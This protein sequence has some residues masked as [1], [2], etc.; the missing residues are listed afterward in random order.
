MEPS[1]HVTNQTSNKETHEGKQ[2][3]ICID[4]A[5]T[6]EAPSIPGLPERFK[7][8]KLLGQ[9]GMG[10]VY[11]VADQELGCDLAVKIMSREWLAD[12][13][14]LQRFEVEAAAAGELCHPHIAQVYGYSAAGETPY[15]TMEYVEGASFDR[16][17]K[18]E[19]IIEQERLL[20]MV[21]QICDALEYAHLH[22]I[23]HRDLKPSNII[24]QD[25]GDIVKLVDFGI[26]KVGPKNDS[27]TQ[28]TQKG[29][30]FG[31]PTYMSPEQSHAGTVDHRT[32]LYS[33]GCIIYEAL[34]G[35][36]LFTGDNAVQILLHHINT[37]PNTSTRKLLKK[38][39][40]K[41]LIAILEKLLQKRPEQRYQSAAEVADDIRRVLNNQM[42]FAL[43][44]RPF[45]LDISKRGVLTG[46]AVAGTIA[47]IGSCSLTALMVAR[48]QTDRPANQGVYD[49]MIQRQNEARN[50]VDKITKSNGQDV[51]LAARALHLLV[52]EDVWFGRNIGP[53]PVGTPKDLLSADDQKAI[54]K[55]YSNASGDTR[56]ELLSVLTSMNNP[57]SDVVNFACALCKSKDSDTR[58]VV[59]P[60][61]S[62]WPDLI[63]KK[64]QPQLSTALSY[65]LLDNKESQSQAGEGFVVNVG[66]EQRGLLCITNFSDE[67]IANIRQSARAVPPDRQTSMLYGG[68][69]NQEHPLGH[70]ATVRHEYYPE[71]LSLLK[72]RNYAQDASEALQTLGAK[73][74]EAVPALCQM[75]K[76]PESTC[77][78]EAAGV[79]AAIGPAA[80]PQA[81]PALSAAYAHH[82]REDV[83]PFASALAKMGPPGIAVL[84]KEAS[85]HLARDR[86]GVPLSG[87][88]VAS[89]TAQEALL[90]ARP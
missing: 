39:Y 11:Q 75:L 18:R 23:V 27:A 5:A 25:A 21:L 7:V 29:E 65:L 58:S 12:Q 51:A 64:Y 13:T 43:L 32:D 77:R 57:T 66:D 2:V 9:G 70:V 85:R 62:R 16:V 22:G 74:L 35:K 24:L 54:L 69:S 80:A 82:R 90:D 45:L 86:D 59:S 19:R 56:L 8:L 49:R 17:L 60:A 79:L 34:S 3:R 20:N 76:A 6:E 55:A 1:A 36:P 84:Q 40:S 83:G 30:V 4:Q 38:G 63:D 37:S 47:L 53:Q 52:A 89:E 68:Y 87:D 10:T 41:S 88:Q 67:A 78:R 50:L 72:N 61:V 73:A 15:I 33:L 71:L 44:K 48:L 28:L 26:A 14:A 81:V 46:L 42:S 31:S